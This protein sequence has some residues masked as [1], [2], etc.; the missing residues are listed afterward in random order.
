MLVSCLLGLDKSPVHLD[1]T[2]GRVGNLLE[3]RRRKVDGAL[4]TSRALVDDSGNDALSVAVDL[5]G[6]ATGA[7]E[8]R[9]RIVEV[10]G[11]KGDDAVTVAVSLTAST[12]TRSV[13]GRITRV[14][15]GDTDGAGKDQDELVSRDHVG[16]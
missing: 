11:G 14:G 16:G 2:L 7:G 6:L 4:V 1:T 10:N 3:R 9:V 15:S 5:D 8:V 12:Y 13:V